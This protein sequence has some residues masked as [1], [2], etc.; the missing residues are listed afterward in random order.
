[1]TIHATSAV[2]P[3]AENDAREAKYNERL[4]L[5][6]TELH[7]LC[8]AFQGIHKAMPD[9]IHEPDRT[10]DF[11]ACEKDALNIGDIDKVDD[12]IKSIREFREHETIP[13]IILFKASG[14]FPQKLRDDF[15]QLLKEKGLHDYRRPGSKAEFPDTHL[16]LR[17]IW[18]VS[19]ADCKPTQDYPLGSHTTIMDPGRLHVTGS[20][21]AE[22]AKKHAPSNA[23]ITRFYTSSSELFHKFGKI[24]L[25]D[26]S[27]LEYVDRSLCTEHYSILVSRNLNQEDASGIELIMNDKVDEGEDQQRETH[28]QPQTIANAHLA[29]AVAATIHPAATSA[30]SVI[31]KVGICGYFFPDTYTYALIYLQLYTYI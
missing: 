3:E 26:I 20:V 11:S 28:T 19:K 23:L 9:P 12:L 15:V 1:M 8:M 2:I 21:L 27:H 30:A 29:V 4:R 13:S 22:F 7:E 24:F 5:S 6:P 25:D 14:F 10:D 16:A 17:P 18:Q 31:L